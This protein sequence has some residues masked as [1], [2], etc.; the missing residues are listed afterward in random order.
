MLRI[1]AFAILTGLSID[2]LR[3][4]DTI[5]LLTPQKTDPATGYRLY[6]E[7]QLVDANR[8]S[9]LKDLGFGL[10]EILRYDKKQIAGMVKEKLAQK[11]REALLIQRQISQL[12][13]ALEATT[14][15]RE[16]MLSIHTKVFAPQNIVFLEDTLKDFPEEGVLWTRFMRLCAEHHVRLS[17]SP[18]SF[19]STLCADFQNHRFVTRI[20]RTVIAR[21]A[22]ADGLSYARLPSRLVASIAF[23][24]SYPHL[25]EM[26]PLLHQWLEDNHY[27]QSGTDF[28]SYYRTPQMESDPDNYITELCIPLLDSRTVPAST[29]KGK[30]ARHG[31]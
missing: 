18:F 30:G 24:G 19:A 7:A 28:R 5:G 11:Q 17:P 29:L 9:A 3:H 25:S 4:Y 23:R 21:G 10:E 2:M 14:S 16:Q 6:D 31:F 12:H 27:R 22:E 20:W 13:K 1:G 8:I 26:I 15:Y